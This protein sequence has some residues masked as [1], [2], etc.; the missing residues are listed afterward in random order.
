MKPFVRI[1]IFKKKKMK[2]KEI[3]LMIM[4]RMQLYDF[5]RIFETGT[6]NKL[7]GILQND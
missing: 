7:Y 2:L 6:Y 4:L 3:P 5:V 1:F